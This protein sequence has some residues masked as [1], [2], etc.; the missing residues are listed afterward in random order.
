MD[1]IKENNMRSDFWRRFKD[2]RK[3]LSG[4]DTCLIELFIANCVLFFS[5]C[6]VKT[7]QLNCSWVCLLFGVWGGVWLRRCQC[8]PRR[9]TYRRR[10]LFLCLCFTAYNMFAALLFCARQPETLVR[11]LGRSCPWVLFL[12]TW[13]YI[14]VFI[15]PHLRKLWRKPGRDDGSNDW[16]V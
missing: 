7:G 1:K 12:W 8:S 16:L 6:A 13:T 9:M 4:W 5:C 2:V 10:V 15:W 3:S 11:S 14:C